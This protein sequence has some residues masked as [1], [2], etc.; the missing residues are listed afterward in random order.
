MLWALWDG[1]D[2]G[3]AAARGHPGAAARPPGWPTAT[4]TRSARCSRSPPAPRSS[5]ATPASATFLA[6]LRA[7]EIPADTLADR[8]VRGDAVRLL[9]AHRSKGLEWRLVVVAHVQE[10]AWPDLRRRDSLLQAD[11][12]GRDGLLP[13]LTRAA[14]LAE[15]RRLFYVAATRARQRLVVTAVQSPDDDGEQPSRFVARARARRAD[16]PRRAGRAGRCRWPAWSPSCAV[17][18]PTPTSP[19]RCATPPP[20]RLAAARRRPTCTAGRS[21][22][23]PTPHLVGAAR[24]DAARERPVRPGDE[25]LTLSASALEGLLTCP[26][27][28]F[29]QREAGG[30]GRQLDQPGLRQGRPRARRADRQGR[31]RRRRRPDAAAST[32]SGAGWSSAPRGPRARER[33]A[34]ADALAGS[35]PGTTDPA[36]APCVATEPR[37]RAEVTL[38]DGQ[39]VRLH[40]YADRLELDEDGRVVVVDLKT[41]K[42]PPT[43]Q[44]VLEHTRSSAS[45]SSPSTTAPPTSWPADR[46]TLR[47]R[48]AGPAPRRRRRCPRCRP[49]RREPGATGPRL[50]EE[51]LMIG[52][53]RRPRA[54]SSSPGPASTA[55]AARSRRSARQGRR[56]G[57]VVTPRPVD[58]PEQLAAT[59]WATTGTFSAQQFAAITAPLE[60]AVVI[61]GAGSGKTTVMAAR[62]VWLVATGQVAPDEVL[63][64]T[65]TT[66][67]TAELAARGS[68]T[69]CARP[70]CCPTAA[71]PGAG[72]DERDEV[73]E[74]TVRD[75][76]RLRLGAALRARPAD[77]P[78][79]RHPADRRRHA[80]T[81]SPPARSQ[82]YTGP[83]DQLTDSPRHVVQYLLA[84]DAEMSE[85]LVTPTT[86][87]R[88]T[89]R[90]RPLFDDGMADRAPQDLP[91]DEREGDRGDR[92]ARRAARPGRGLPRRSRRSLGLMDFSDQIALAAR[93]ADER[94]EVG[95]VEREQV[96]GRAARRVPGHLGRPGADAQ[97]ALLRRR[98]RAGRGH[99]VTAVGDPNQAIY[100]WRGASVSNILEFGDDFPARRRRD[101][102][103]VP[104]H[105]QPALRRADPRRPPTTSPPTLYAGRPELLPL[106]AEAGRGS[107]ARCTAIVHETYDDELAWLADRGD[108]RPTPRC[109]RA[110]AGARSAC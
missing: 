91:R 99:P 39:V 28:W 16:A 15:E 3:R 6:T 8:G 1:T 32:R 68:A 107:R 24:A 61:A 7:Q 82:R 11:R 34:V 5:A 75:L 38:P 79:A 109:A 10:G 76:P 44:P 20:R 30:R 23:R 49:S 45:T 35:S 59:C 12:I 64:L 92:Q 63:G 46:C 94:P 14:M 54:R 52:R 73:E 67:A 85:H 27:Q 56:D 60:P 2:W 50:V 86:C 47:W 106:E 17:P 93:L 31:A 40:G 83:V 55:S 9:T 105:G 66:K 4:S 103:D 95:E 65:F 108:R 53:R 62:V 78:R 13:P 80:A 18:S 26:A 87:A 77:R 51:Q 102:R 43:G 19:S 96:P 48:R 41:G 71:P 90:Q 100:G 70:G 97:P 88:T 33:E 36:R 104:A 21:R 37:L 29:L 98:R 72:D 101:A 57:A 84:L 22:P 81:S 69:A 25:P 89:P 110:G 42:Y 74:P 58:T